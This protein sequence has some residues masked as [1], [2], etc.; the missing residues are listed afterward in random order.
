MPIQRHIVKVDN[1][2]WQEK[3]VPAITPDRRGLYKLLCQAHGL[4]QFEVRLTRI[5]PGESNTWHHTHSHCEEWFLITKGSC[6]IHLNGEWSELG[7]GTSLATAPGDYH[8]FR[9]FGEAPCEFLIV[10]I[11]HPEDR[12]T[13][14]EEPPPPA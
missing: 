7:E 4:K 1:L 13:R 3:R 10:G 6:H 2:P 14:I 5:E 9:N 12:A 8:I 11:E